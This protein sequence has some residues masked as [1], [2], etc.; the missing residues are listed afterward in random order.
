VLGFSSGGVIVAD[1][2]ARR[3]DVRCAV[4]GSAPL[5]LTQYYRRP[6]GSLP[7]YFAMRSDELADP[8]RAVPC[9][10]LGR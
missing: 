5:D 7:D 8:M 10:P 4:I 2:L 6:D 3:S 9:Y 1:L